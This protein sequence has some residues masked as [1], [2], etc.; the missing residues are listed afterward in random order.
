MNLKHESYSEPLHISD[1]ALKPRTH[2]ANYTPYP[3]PK[4][5]FMKFITENDGTPLNPK[6]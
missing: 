5:L 6:P 1:P 3:F 2:N 4:H